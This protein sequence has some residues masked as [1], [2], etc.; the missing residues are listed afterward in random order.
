MLRGAA[1]KH[2]LPITK[3]SAFRAHG[4]VPHFLL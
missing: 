1:N 2:V 3:P 4:K